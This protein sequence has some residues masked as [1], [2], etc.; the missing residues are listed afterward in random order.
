MKPTLHDRMIIDMTV[1]SKSPG[2]RERYSTC[3][4]VLER[5]LEVPLEV[6]N[7]GHVAE[8]MRHLSEERQLAPRTLHLYVCALRCLFRETLKRPEV[9]EGLRSPRVTPSVPEVLT[10]KEVH[11]LFAHMRSLRHYTIANLLYGM[12]CGSVRPSR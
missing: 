5:L 4:R 12:A 9:V 1:S 11:R 8:L 3:I 10:H 2:T 6:A 7:R